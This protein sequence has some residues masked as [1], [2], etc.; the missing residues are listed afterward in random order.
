MLKT[1]LVVVVLLSICA[2]AFS[3]YQAMEEFLKMYDSLYQRLYTVNSEAYWAA[4][5]D[6]S[7]IHTGERIGADKALAAFQGSTYILDRS[8][9]F[10]KSKDQLKPLEAR[11]IEKILYYG[12]HAPGTI[13]DI[14]SERVAAEAK[15][16][17]TL[18][19]FVFCEQKEGDKCLKPITTNQIDDILKDS[20]D[21]EQREKIWEVSKE[22]GI[23]LKPGL[24]E[25]QKLRNRIAKETGYSSYF[26]LEVSDYGMTVPEMM[27]LTQ[28]LVA[29]LKPLYQQL[30]TW[31]KHELAA[32]YKQPVPKMIPAHWL[33]NR[34]SQ[35]W[36]GIVEG[37][38]LDPLFKSKSKEW[39]IQQAEKFY[40]SMGM[41]VLPKSFWEKS[42]LY[43][44]PPGS[45]RKKNTHA[46]A[47]HIDLDKDVRSLMSVKPDFNWFGTTH[48]ELGHIYYYLAY[49]TPE[50]PL[51]LREGA[52]RAFH[53]GIGD[54][55]KIAASQEPYLREI[56]LLPVDQKIDQN[57][58][59][60]NQALDEVIFIPWSAG[61][62]TGWE[63]DFYEKSLSPDE[64]NKRWW[65]Y[66]AKYQ[67]VAPPEPRAEQFCD[68]ATKTHI[69]DDPAQYYDYALA[70]A[71]KYQLH[72]HI[73]RKIL[74]TDPNNANYYGNKEVGKFLWDLLKLG[75]TRDW[76]EVLKEKTGEELSTRAM[77]EYFKPLMAYLQKE[78]H[79][80]T[81]TWE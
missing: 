11:Q 52:N 71:I 65:E 63:Y 53:E 19:G 42:D 22:S 32:R 16:S 31:T 17:A 64:Y 70:A 54:L 67:G 18:D 26:A 66:V 41:P 9:N 40:T 30:H 28:K 37:V 50:V 23:A 68:P 51:T 29:D 21:L 38:D 60:L 6:V 45:K 61:V 46:S 34:W 73:S 10:L 44:L 55:I 33:G 57:K 3:Q 35:D 47:W 4:G 49:S 14:V 76:R 72:D 78:N 79:G 56:G 81:V 74:K 15:Q 59:L 20:R 58:W 1:K 80:R 43:D 8:R 27:A 36:P 7:E 75:Q 77:L 2:V 12:A 62:M 13:S 25:L 69:N 39:V 5:T 24:I 48:H